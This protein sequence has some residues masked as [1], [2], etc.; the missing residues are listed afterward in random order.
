[1][2]E[3]PVVLITGAAGA[4]GTALVKAFAAA[5]YRI[6]GSDLASEPAREL[7][8]DVDLWTPADV[9]DAEQMRLVVEQSVTRL[10]RLDVLVVNAG[11]TALGSF[12]DTSD[13]TF[14]RVMKVN[15]HGAIYSARA[16]LP[17]LRRSRGR[18]VVLS[19]V[20][21]FAPVAGRPAY[22]ASKHA[23][24]GLFESIRHELAADGVGLTMVYPS[25]LRTSPTDLND[26]GSHAQPAT[27]HTTGSLLDADSVA[28]RIVDAVRDGRDRI[29]PGR[30][31]QLAYLTHRLSPG[32]YAR[33]MVRRLSAP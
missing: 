27:R 19:S 17:A 12:A 32:L 21:G 23:V 9:T 28:R 33:L 5:G 24:T 10:G 30:V 16:A 15:L 13:D 31:A 25:F 18:I 26:A 4:I 3:S 7:A 11:V 1:M 6:I 20:A 2:A 29:R 14:V 8:A 22:S